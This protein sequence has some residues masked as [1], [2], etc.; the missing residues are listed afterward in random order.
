MK[1]YENN[2]D[3]FE[4][5]FNRSVKRR[6][7][8][9]DYQLGKVLIIGNSNDLDK[10]SNFISEYCP[11]IQSY[12]YNSTFNWVEFKSEIEK[13]QPDLI[14]I[15]RQLGISNRDLTY[16]VGPILESITQE[17]NIPVLVIPHEFE[18]LK[19]ETIGI[20][21]DHQIDNS[22]LINKGLLMR[23]HLKNIELIHIEDESIFNYYLDAIAK[24][25]GINT[26]Y[27]ETN[28]KETI[29][30]LSGDFFKDVASNLENETL[31]A[32]IHCKFGDTVQS[33]GELIK[34]RKIDLLVFAAEDDSKMAMHSLGHSLTIQFPNVA[35]LLV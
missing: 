2:L 29:L 31:K 20:G 7:K 27:A 33:Y 18:G 4:S 30:D 19:I 5:I 22:N 17:I 12:E 11:E 35:T 32:G 10:L 3:I 23:R 25:P 16:S 1:S 28:I 14:L 34:D 8:Y 9:E 15:E 26:E 21:F 24:I 13:A 6:Y